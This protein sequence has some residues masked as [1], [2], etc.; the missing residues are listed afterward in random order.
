[1]RHAA[2][3]VLFA[4]LAAAWF[5]SLAMRPLYKADESRYG[6]ISR[7]MAVS[8]DW[9]TPRLNGFRYFEKPPLQYWAT[10]AAFEAFG[11]GD[12]TARL[13]TALLAAAGVALTYF[14][15]RRLFGRPAGALAAALLGASPLYLLLGQFNS[16][17]MSVSV[18]LAAAIF[19]FALRRW[20]LFWLACALAVL[21]KGLIGVVLPLGTIGL[22]IVVRRGWPLLGSMRLV[23]GGLLFLAVSAPWF[24]AV[25]LA[26]PEFLHFF[27]IQEHLQ[28]FTTHMHHRNEPWWFFIPVLAAGIAPWLLLLPG[29]LRSAFHHRT[30]GEPDAPILLGLWSVLVFVFFSLSGSKLP[31]YILPTVPALALLVGRWI[32]EA[33]PRRLLVAQAL[34]ALL[35]GLALAAGASVLVRQVPTATLS[36]ANDYYPWLV[37]AGIALAAPSAASLYCALRARTLAAVGWLALGSFAATLIALDGHRTLAAG[38]SVESMVQSLPAPI[39]AQ[40]RVYAVNAYDH[41]IPWTLRRTVTMVAYDDELD[42]AITWEPQKFIADLPGFARAWNEPGEAYAFFALRDFDRMRADLN[43]PMQV[44]GRGLRYVIVRKP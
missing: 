42:K 27:F 25:S 3:G 12:W 28:R 18:F 21:S 19:A 22:Y 26:N 34:L 35:G 29:A 11:V 6:E 23:S 15:G 38:Y 14:A 30:S 41:T 40:A 5:G 39:P 7:E 13:W 33:R 17:D 31:S 9:I 16:L 44:E 37:A 10:A 2:L 20:L 1:M 8:G 43:L 36:L 32:E 24:I 4:L